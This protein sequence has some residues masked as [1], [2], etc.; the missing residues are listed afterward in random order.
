M[1]AAR[2]TA[3]EQYQLIIECRKSGMTD[4]DWC[5]ANGI[6]PETFYTWV[7]RLKKRGGFP[8]PPVTRHVPYRG[9]EH[10]IVRVDVL[11]DESS[12]ES[13]DNKN[14]VIAPPK[15]QA[16]FYSSIEIEVRGAVFRFSEPVDIPAYEKT[17]LMIGERI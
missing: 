4:C 8:I 9:M 15:S 3:E 12:G 1:R 5:R 2:K 11:P 16:T 6:N 14:T 10:D 17:L 7:Q 13:L